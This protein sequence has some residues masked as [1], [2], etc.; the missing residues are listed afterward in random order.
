MAKTRTTSPL[1]RIR[2]GASAEQY[3]GGL[4]GRKIDVLCAVGRVNKRVTSGL[5]L[6]LFGPIARMSAFS[7]SGPST[8]LENAEMTVRLRPKADHQFVTL[9]SDLGLP[10]HER[11]SIE[12]EEVNAQ[13]C[14]QPSIIRRKSRQDTGRALCEILNRLH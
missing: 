12:G 13:T 3:L 5:V 1:S 6:L 4:S 8:S 14:S 10:V 7:E 11:L 2:R 9:H